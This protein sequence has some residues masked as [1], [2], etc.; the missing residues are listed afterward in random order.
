LAELTSSPS[1]TARAPLVPAVARALAVMDLLAR[2][3]APLH[4]AGVAAALDLPKSSVHGLCNTL[5]SFGWLRRADNGA[6]QIGPGVMPLAGAFVARTS[7]AQEFNALWHET[8]AAPEETILLSVLSGSD[9]VYVGARIGTRPLGLAF[10]VG[11][12]LPAHLAATGKAM[13]AF[14]DPAQV[15]T[16]FGSGALPVMTGKGPRRIA[17]LV[18]ELALTRERGYS[19]DDEGVREGVICYGAPVFDASGVPVAGVGVCLNKAMLAKGGG[20]RHQ[21]HVMQAARVLS[22]RLGAPSGVPA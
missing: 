15:R 2:E 5:L 18:K 10:N 14:L 7:V 9:V 11:M 3:P 4:M 20:E 21:R 19:I 13:L 16:R 1:S 17:D 6:L 8:G 22:Q 12:H